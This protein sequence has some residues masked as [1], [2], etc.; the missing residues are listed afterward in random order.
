MEYIP[1]TK[2]D[3]PNDI[4]DSYNENCI[5]QMFS[6][7][8]IGTIIQEFE[9]TWDIPLT[10]ADAAMKFLDHDFIL[11]KFK[12]N[13]FGCINNELINDKLAE[14]ERTLKNLHVQTSTNNLFESDP[15]GNGIGIGYRINRCINIIKSW[16]LVLKNYRIIYEFT[17]NPVSGEDTFDP[18]NLLAPNA[19][20]PA[21][22]DD[23][24][25]YQNCIVYALEKLKQEKHKRYK[26][27]VC[28]QIANTKAWK[29]KMTIEDYIETLFQKE[30]DI[31]MWRKFTKTGANRKN[32]IEHLRCCVDPMFPELKKNRHVFSFSDGIFV[33]KD[34]SIDGWFHFYPYNSEQFKKMPPNLVAAKYFDIPFGQFDYKDWREIETPVLD[35]ILNYQEFD[36]DVKRW[37]YIFIGRMAFDVNELDKWQVVPFHKG[38]ASTGK[39]KLCEIC[40]HFYEGEDV[41][42]MSDL[43]EKNFGLSAI[44]DKFL[45]V[46]PEVTEKFGLGQAEFQS[47]VSGELVSVAQKFKTAQAIEWTVPGM[48]AGNEPP[49]YR[50]NSGSI[51]RR[52]VIFP[53]QNQVQPEDM[54][55][56]LPQKLKAETAKILF[57]CVWAYHEATRMYRKAGI[58][59]VFPSTL[60]KAKEEMSLSTNALRHFMASERVEFGPDK[61]VPLSCLIEEFNC[62]CKANNLGRYKFT[63]DFYNGPFGSKKM[64]VE[65][66][67]GEYNGKVYSRQ[68]WVK[69]IDLLADDFLQNFSN[70]L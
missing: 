35:T 27:W 13:D 15:A 69:G 36:D 38:M 24:N 68:K 43:P 54:D 32:L 45:F 20:D 19:M 56:E 67:S 4:R 47:M 52:M 59:S 46:T 55:M 18:S 12:V 31:H 9:I 2:K 33:A 42:Q 49:G 60:L 16:E 40:A 70:D 53:F 30:I 41:G 25:D 17:K 28:S 65:G 10:D 58:W 34:D 29:K 5:A 64:S 51:Q 26:G 8:E 61:M 57:K 37:M 7:E 6:P 23:N 48:F 1:I 3:N 14:A 39:G 66:Y 22:N 21:R 11:Q 44:F 62:H 63:P 50:D